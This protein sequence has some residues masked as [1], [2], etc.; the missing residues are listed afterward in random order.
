M[1]SPLTVSLEGRISQK[2][3]ELFARCNEIAR[4]IIRCDPVAKFILGHE[5]MELRE[6][7]AIEVLLRGRTISVRPKRKIYPGMSARGNGH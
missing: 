6:L 5:F 1:A 3:E 2:F 7:T 4:V